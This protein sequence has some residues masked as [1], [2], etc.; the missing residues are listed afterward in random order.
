MC[1]SAH[2]PIRAAC[3]ASWFTQFHCSPAV[4]PER[5]ECSIKAMLSA[6]LRDFRVAI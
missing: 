1:A 6:G 4:P 2:G 3:C 5:G